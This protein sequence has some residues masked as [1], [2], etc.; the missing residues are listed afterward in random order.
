MPVDSMTVQTILVLVCW[1]FV[2]GLADDLPPDSLSSDESESN[3]PQN[4]TE[5]STE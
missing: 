5:T 1:L 3:A 2:A 4:C